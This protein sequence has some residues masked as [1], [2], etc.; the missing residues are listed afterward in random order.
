M[1]AV[2]IVPSDR[3]EEEEGHRTLLHLA[4]WRASMDSK[5]SGSTG[6]RRVGLFQEHRASRLPQVL[7][8][9]ESHALHRVI[10]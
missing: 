3:D 8:S 10:K 7:L 2:G 5:R 1:C 6:W 4:T 9:R